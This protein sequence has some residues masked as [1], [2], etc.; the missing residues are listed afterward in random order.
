MSIFR[1]GSHNISGFDYMIF[2]YLGSFQGINAIGNQ[3]CFF[4]RLVLNLN[5]LI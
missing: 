2:H 5:I 4:E 3:I 1:K